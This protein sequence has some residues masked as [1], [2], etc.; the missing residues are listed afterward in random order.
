MHLLLTRADGNRV[1]L[2][3]SNHSAVPLAEGS[4]LG[5][6]LFALLVSRNE[7]KVGDESL[8]MRFDP[9]SGRVWLDSADFRSASLLFVRR[10]ELQAALGDLFGA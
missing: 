10:W 6:E 2:M 8:G 5:V 7:K 3:L 4:A 1:D 9:R